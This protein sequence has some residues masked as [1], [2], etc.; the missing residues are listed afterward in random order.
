MADPVSIASTVLLERLPGLIDRR[1][2]VGALLP[3]VL[4]GAA[5]LGLATASGLVDA[6]LLR[7]SIET[8]FEMA[9]AVSILL[10]LWLVAAGLTAA[11]YIVVR[12]LEGYSLPPPF[13]GWLRRW[14]LRK[15][16]RL[17]ARIG[18]A[19]EGSLEHRRLLCLRAT[20]Y[21]PREEEVRP[22]AFGNV[23]RAFESYAPE[24]YGFESTRGWTR[25]LAVLP[26][27]FRETVDG[28]RSQVNLLAHLWVLS[29]LF[30]AEYLVLGLWT[31]ELA[32]PWFAVGALLGVRL[33]S[34][35][36]RAAAVRW[37]E[38][39]K[40]GFDVFLP[41]LRRRLD[42]PRPAT[43][44]EER[45]MWARF[46]ETFLTGD[47]DWLPPLGAA[48]VRPPRGPGREGGREGTP[49]LRPVGGAGP[50]AGAD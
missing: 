12:S 26:K 2:V 47:P 14:E 35:R 1:L 18:A 23:V 22:T 38:T 5:S 8:E 15:F 44:R 43:R 41:E 4:F 27:D 33:W 45:E 20:L 49:H 34:W 36:A 37:G 7:E 46:S 48:S 17:R 11:N 3:L 9:E 42:L 28:T 30:L 6:G 24:V 16:R 10:S 13:A 31:G 40:A 39:V 50:E 19:E 29:W 32:S 21:P 25:L